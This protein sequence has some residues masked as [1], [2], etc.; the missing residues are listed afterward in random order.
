MHNSWFKSV[1]Q[2]H[3]I[4][5]R[6]F[7]RDTGIRTR[8]LDI[9]VQGRRSFHNSPLWLAVKVAD[10]LGIAAEELLQKSDD[11]V[12]EGDVKK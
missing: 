12:S 6:Q 1:L 7:E 8:T 5:V 9:Y 4:S 2:S 3:G 11:A 10:G